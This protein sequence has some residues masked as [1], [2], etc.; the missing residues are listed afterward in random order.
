MNK[1]YKDKNIIRLMPDPAIEARLSGKSDTTLVS[2]RLTD[3]ELRG[4]LT[5]I[6]IRLETLEAASRNPAGG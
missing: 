3:D 1:A 5:R 2:G 4:I 6:L